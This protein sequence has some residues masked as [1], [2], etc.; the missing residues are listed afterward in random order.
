MKKFLLNCLPYVLF[1]LIGAFFAECL[2]RQTPNPYRFKYEWMQSNSGSVETL[3]LGS[4]H[5]FYGIKPSCLD[6]VAFNLANVSQD[7]SFDR[8]LLEYW[9]DSY[10]RLKTVIVPVSYFSWVDDDIVSGNESYRQRYYR[11]YMDCDL[12]PGSF[13]SGLEVSNVASAKEKFKK[14]LMWDKDAGCDEN[15]WGT[16]F[17][18][19][20]SP[21]EELDDS[22]AVRTVVS[23]STFSNRY[24]VDKNFQEMKAIAAFCKEHE[25]Q[26]ILVTTPCWHLYCDFLDKSQLENMYEL[27]DSIVNCYGAL[28]LDYMNDPRFQPSDFHDNNHLSE[29][30]AQ[31]FTQLLNTDITQLRR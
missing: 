15:G 24:M 27:A 21:A 12:Y 30:G 14:V 2:L 18:P 22:L 5:T 28:Y 6:G 1:I 13:L 31:K 29:K 20:V 26:L 8:Y 7:Y 10:L 17:A 9:K 23:H 4:S 16:M 25:I 11:L 19:A 3:V